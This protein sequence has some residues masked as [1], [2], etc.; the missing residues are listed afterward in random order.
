MSGEIKKSSLLEEKLIQQSSLVFHAYFNRDM[1]TFVKLLDEDFVWIG[2]YDF[3]YS[4]GIDEFLAITKDEQN[5]SA[6]MVYDEEYQILARSDNAY[7]VYG[8]FSAS[9]WKNAETFLYTRQRATF[10]WKLTHDGFK[11][12]HLHCTMARDIPLEGNLDDI[13]KQ[14]DGV[15]R[16]YDYMILAENKHLTQEERILFKDIDGGIH[17]LLPSE[18]LY[19]SIMYRDTTIYTS[20]QSFCIRKNLNQLHEMMPFLVQCHKSWLVN[21]LYIAEIRRYVI[22]LT[23]NLQVPIGKSR[24]NEVRELLKIA[25]APPPEY[26][27]SVKNNSYF[28]RRLRQFILFS[29][30]KME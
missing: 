14:K 8:R 12:L 26:T 13:T 23:N 21:P 19:V 5:E 30:T 27:H 10:I 3:Q 15:H 18:I 2:S 16:W 20:T 17:Y 4:R 22:T 24:Y 9:A 11:L 28:K 25:P 1:D 7:V 29:C 6:A